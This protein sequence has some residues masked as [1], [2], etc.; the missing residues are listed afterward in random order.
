MRVIRRLRIVADLRNKK[1]AR[2]QLG[3][4]LFL[5]KSREKLREKS[6]TGS[7]GARDKRN[8]KRQIIRNSVD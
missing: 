6:F 3:K 2:R 7:D 4:K 5:I 8:D 1:T